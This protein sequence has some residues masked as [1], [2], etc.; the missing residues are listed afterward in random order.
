MAMADMTTAKRRRMLQKISS[1]DADTARD[2]MLLAS[3]HNF[4][5]GLR[6]PE[7]LFSW[8]LDVIQSLCNDPGDEMS[9]R[10]QHRLLCGIALNT[11]YSGL[12]CPREALEMG[13]QAL[14]HHL[15][16]EPPRVP[17]W[18]GRTCDKGAIQKK[19]QVEYSLCCE[20][21][22]RCHFEDILDRLPPEGR[23][24]INAATPDKS[25]SREQRAE[26]FKTI[27]EWVMDNRSWLFPAD[28]TSFCTVHRRQCRVHP[29]DAA[30]SGVAVENQ[31]LRVNVAGVTCHAWSFEGLGEGEA[32]ES[33]IPL[34]VWTA[35]RVV[36]FERK[37]EDIA[38]LECAPKFPAKEK[39]QQPF[40]DLAS[41]F[42]WVDGPEWHGW[43]H[44]RTRVLAAAVNNLTLD[45]HGSQDNDELQEEYARRFHRQMVS[46]GDL[47]LQA[48]E[49]ERI[50]EMMKIA[51]A[52]KN[53]VTVGEMTQ[54]VQSQDHDKLS[55]LVFPPGGIQR[56]NGWIQLYQEKL[57][58]T[59]KLRAFLCDVDHSPAGGELWP[60]QLTH[61][62][63][64]SLRQNGDQTTWLLATAKEHLGALG[65]RMFGD[66]PIF[67]KS[68]MAKVL[69]NLDFSPSQ[70]KQ[71]SGN[72]MHLRTQLAFMMFAI[73]NVSKKKPAGQ[74]QSLTSWGDDGDS[75]PRDS[76]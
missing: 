46:A 23:D 47:L 1:L 61:G 76:L 43:P 27:R 69:D 62:S 9:M 18:V 44:R 52:R 65:W 16:T 4:P 45:W 51:V 40:G 50:H 74:L 55:S 36:R 60:T 25:L 20:D 66:S 63:V 68:K 14:Q 35:E 54:I 19:L 29:Q 32:H 48:D 15:K 57:K 2:P 72:S 73:A 75:F 21:G 34:A 28:A 49:K 42:A 13:M 10:L 33:E 31:R 7:E 41:V 58:E 67:P 70:V 64:L 11:D 17:V 22:N 39:L 26:A 37:E 38:F 8:P 12:D 59:A 3:S 53:N 30:D 6:T 24:W 71:L 5:P 56:M